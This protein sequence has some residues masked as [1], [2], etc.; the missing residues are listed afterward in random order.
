MPRV[1]KVKESESLKVTKKPEY[2]FSVEVNDALYEGKADSLLQALKDYV[3]SDKFPF[4]IKTKALVK[5]GKGKAESQQFYSPFEARK[6]FA[7]AE[8]KE[9]VLEILAAKFEARLS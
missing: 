6:V 8:F 2:W 5:F 4:A 3:A 9:S 1:K 7:R